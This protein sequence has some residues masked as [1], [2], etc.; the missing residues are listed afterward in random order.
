[1]VCVFDFYSPALGCVT[2]G[3]AVGRR[4]LLESGK[5]MMLLTTL[6]PLFEPTAAHAFTVPAGA[7]QV[8]FPHMCSVRVV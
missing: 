6:A 7:M 4:E 1:V 8:Q 3:G 5:K 2:M